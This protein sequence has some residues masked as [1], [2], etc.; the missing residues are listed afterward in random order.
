MNKKTITI[1]I[2]S[3]QLD[4]ITNQELTDNLLV[5]RRSKFW[6]YIM[7]YTTLRLDTV[8][9]TL[10]SIDPIK[11]GTE[12]ARAQGIRQGLLDMVDTCQV[13][14]DRDDEEKKEK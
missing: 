10:R 5:L 13:L 14:K 12:I 2:D 7:K 11:F 6:E 8:D 4:D 1:E 3:D 9:Q